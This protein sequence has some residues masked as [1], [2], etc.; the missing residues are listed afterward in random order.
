MGVLRGLANAKHAGLARR[1]RALRDGLGIAGL[2]FAV[3]LFAI[4]APQAR[5]VGF[6]AYAYWH[7]DIEHP[8]RLAAGAFGAF[9]YTPAAARLFAP[10]GALPWPTFLWLWLAGLIATM[11]WLGWRRALL[12]LAFPPVAVELYHGNIHLLMAAAIALGFRYP[13][14]WAFILLTKV[15]PGI[16]LLWFAVRREWR[17]LAIALGTTAAITVVSLAVDGRL[18]VEWWS[19]AILRVTTEGVGQP[20]LPIP[21][22]LRLPAA[23]LLVAWGALT[24]RR[25]TVP[26]A[27][28]LSLP[29]LWFSGLA[30][31]A[32]LPALDRPELLERTEPLVRE[33]RLGPIEAPAS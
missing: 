18:W 9:T 6:D 30:I 23:A 24:N 19:N 12:V 1:G 5:T 20:S 26:A 29:V 10:A 11:V 7:L 3:Y 16:G 13:A 4:V 31:L 17:S 21:L 2:L 14:T 8:Y 32:A 22:A 25:W 28:V 15:T 33:R 27:A